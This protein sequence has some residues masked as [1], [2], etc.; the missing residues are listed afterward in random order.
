[1]VCHDWYG[2]V[3]LIYHGVLSLV[4][5]GVFDIQYQQTPNYNGDYPITITGQCPLLIQKMVRRLP[6]HS[7]LPTKYI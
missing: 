4:R 5:V 6:N 7:L 2:W 1:M 3:Y